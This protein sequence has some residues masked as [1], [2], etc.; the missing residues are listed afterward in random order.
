MADES[1]SADKSEKPS[2]HKLKKARE[3]GQVAR[4]KDLAT[5][6]G[7]IVAL[8][9]TALL[10]PGW[11]QDFR[12]LF[13]LGMADLSGDGTPENQW[14]QLFGATLWLLA[15][16][17]A[18][19]LAI[20]LAIVIAGLI[21]GGWVLSAENLKPKLQ[22][23]NPVA[24]LGRIVSAK[25]LSEFAT[26]AVKA[27]TLLVV[28]YYVCTA[29][30]EDF[31]RL[32]TRPLP[33][34]ISLGAE[35]ML[36]AILSLCLV[37]VVFALIDVP[38][39]SFFFLKGQRMTKQ[40][41]KEEHKINEGRPEVKQRIRNLQ[42]QIS[43]RSINKTVPTADVVIVNPQ[44]YAVALK[45]DPQRAEAP[46]VVA[47]GVDET[48]LYIREVA[49]RH[50]VEVVTLPP[51]ARA[52]YNTSQVNQQIPVLLYKAVAQVLTYVLQIKAFRAGQRATEPRL[53][54]SLDVP[55]HLS[56]NLR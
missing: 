4:S 39:Q 8:K 10:A 50:Q 42:L 24:N 27:I 13:A 52:I 36:G 17:V 45:Y 19:L 12:Q 34:A 25:H 1:S 6:V 7:L 22:R 53:P 31:L 33:E 5:A 54:T 18:P 23:L 30:V 3:Q 40:E 16:M 46:F 43:R 28:G 35:L 32:Q 48:A 11:L 38:V 9:L 37:F 26:S 15:K 41:V 14:S 51:L 55:E 29:G 21:P 44:H 47:K 49:A 56:H 2:P 20:P